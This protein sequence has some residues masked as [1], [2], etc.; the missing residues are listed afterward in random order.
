METKNY[1]VEFNSLAGD[2]TTIYLEADGESVN[3]LF[4]VI[5]IAER[6]ACV[7]DNCYRSIAEAQAAWPDAIP[8]K[9]YHLTGNAIDQNYTL[10]GGSHE[11]RLCEDQGNTNR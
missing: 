5:S 11:L 7:V 4:A 2:D 8:P 10:E 1:I 9:P 3:H 6:G